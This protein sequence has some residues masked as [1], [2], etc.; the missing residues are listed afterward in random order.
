MKKR[1]TKN[2]ISSDGISF[3]LPT[4]WSSAADR[5]GWENMA[6]MVHPQFLRSDSSCLNGV[7]AAETLLNALTYGD[8][9]LFAATLPSAE[10]HQVSE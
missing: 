9:A 2:G 10:T 3:Y 8:L 7:D 6:E 4:D 1:L 5:R